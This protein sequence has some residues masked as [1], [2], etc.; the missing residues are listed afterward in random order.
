MY[1]PLVFAND[2]MNIK[3]PRRQAIVNEMTLV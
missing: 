2:G 3:H 1:E